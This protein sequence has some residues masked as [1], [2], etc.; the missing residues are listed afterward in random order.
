MSDTKNWGLLARYENPAELLHACETV[1]DADY[2]KWDACSPFPVHGLD[3]AM[4]ITPTPLPWFVLVGGVT[5]A[6]FA[7]GFMYWVSVIAY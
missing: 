6:T 5:G 2:K 4:G 3:G 7:M 1:R